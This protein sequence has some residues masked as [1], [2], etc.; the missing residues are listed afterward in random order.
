MQNIFMLTLLICKVLLK[1]LMLSLGIMIILIRI[2]SELFNQ[3]KPLN[4][5]KFNLLVIILHGFQVI[6]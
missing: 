6:Y 3:L 4:S 2:I 5:F 1:L